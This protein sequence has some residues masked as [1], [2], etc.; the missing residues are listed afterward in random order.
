MLNQL[1]FHERC[2][3][4]VLKL[5]RHFSEKGL[6]FF[7][8]DLQEVYQLIYDN[9][10]QWPRLYP[11]ETENRWELTKE[12]QVIEVPSYDCVVAYQY[13]PG[14]IVVVLGIMQQKRSWRKDD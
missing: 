7:K 12:I 4:D 14:A 11:L 1:L 9:P 3:S 8:N 5:A 6:E 10:H 2:N 13:I